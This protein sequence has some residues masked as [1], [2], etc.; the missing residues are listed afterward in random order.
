M[1]TLD[2]QTN[3]QKFERATVPNEKLFNSLTFYLSQ[4]KQS[5]NFFKLIIITALVHETVSH[6]IEKSIHT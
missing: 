1:N 2:S 4:K 5:S 3:E 6:Q